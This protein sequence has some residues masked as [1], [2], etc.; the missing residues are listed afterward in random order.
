MLLEVTRIITVTTIA[1]KTIPP[2]IQT[3]GATLDVVPAESASLNSSA[4]LSVIPTSEIPVV[5][6]AT[7]S[8][9]LGTG[10]GNGWECFAEG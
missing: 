6:A 10:I 9:S 4:T 8:D 5:V 3:S 2:A 7:E 1:A